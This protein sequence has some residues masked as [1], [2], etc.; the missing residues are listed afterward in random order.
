MDVIPP[1]MGH[2]RPPEPVELLRAHLRETHSELIERADE[3]L[4]LAERL[5]PVEE[6]TDDWADKIA[7][8]V[9]SCTK[10]IKHAEA[11][12]MAANEPHRAQIAAT[13]AFFKGMSEPVRVLKTRMEHRHLT[14]WQK[15]KA[16]QE[17]HRRMAAAAEAQRIAD[18]ERARSR[19]EAAALRKIK[20]AEAEAKAGD[21]AAEA[22]RL[23]AERI[24]QEREAAAA[25]ERAR[26]AAQERNTS[27][28]AA[29]ANAAD[30]S[31]TRTDLGALA[32]LR[33]TYGFHIIDPSKV[34][35]RYLS[36]NE[37]AIRAAIRAATVD[38]T[39][40]L[41]IPGVEI[42]PITTSVVR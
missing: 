8:A 13:D 9:K 14:P 22:E 31:R 34:P 7:E 3:L 16:A 27:E 32:S 5:P 38:G 15:Q 10:F 21:D 41:D 20:A 30:L 18:E 29:H 33:T 23:A 4:G 42:F 37:P 2:N 36:V 25:R 28:R 19:A 6:M 35:R 39:C 40:Q 12:R 17:L 24:E 11:S 26:V 1:T